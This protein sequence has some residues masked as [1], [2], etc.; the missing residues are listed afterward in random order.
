MWGCEGQ[1]PSGIAFGRPRDLIALPA[2]FTQS[3]LFSLP[4]LCLVSRE[5]GPLRLCILCN[6]GW[7]AC[8][9]PGFS[10]SGFGFRGLVLPTPL[11][12][13][14]RLS[15]SQYDCFC[16]SLSPSPV[17][18]FPM[19]LV[20][21]WQGVSWNVCIWAAIL[22]WETLQSLSTIVQVRWL[23]TNT[24]PTC[25]SFDTPQVFQQCS[26]SVIAPQTELQVCP[27]RYRL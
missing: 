22:A 14:C 12:L 4:P 25:S 6:L 19:S 17:T 20:G 9:C 8:W 7:V 24:N 5:S 10:P 21:F 13:V 15:S 1:L 3:Y 16:L 27:N 11:P 26:Y 23:G 18:P 2:I